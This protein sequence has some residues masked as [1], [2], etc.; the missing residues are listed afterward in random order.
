MKTDESIILD[1]FSIVHKFTIMKSSPSPIQDPLF[2][3]RSG[4]KGNTI[5]LAYMKPQTHTP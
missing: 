2:G 3:N 1:Q 5:W 4:K